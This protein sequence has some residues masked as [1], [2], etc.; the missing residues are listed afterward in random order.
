MGIIEELGELYHTAPATGSPW[1]ERA[2]RLLPQVLTRLRELEGALTGLEDRC[3][4]GWANTPMPT[5]PELLRRIEAL[6]AREKGC[7][8]DG[9]C[10]AFCDPDTGTHERRCRYAPQGEVFPGRAVVARSKAAVPIVQCDGCGRTISVIGSRC[11]VCRGV[12]PASAPDLRWSAGPAPTGGHCPHTPCCHCQ[13]HSNGCRSEAEGPMKPGATVPW[14]RDCAIALDAPSA[15]P[16]A[17][18]QR[19]FRRELDSDQA[20]FCEHANEN[21]RSCPCPKTCYCWQPGRTCANKVS[22]L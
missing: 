9:T 15:A 18:G 21:P 14:G 12:A 10:G 3:G 20:F 7:G 4:L 11:A 6:E 1:M 17:V 13:P 5:T 16:A 19:E 22:T 2:Y 8:A